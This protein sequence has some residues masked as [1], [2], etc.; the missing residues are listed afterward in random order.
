MILKGK[1]VDAC[2]VLRLWLTDDLIHDAYDNGADG[3]PIHPQYLRSRNAL[4]EN[5]DGFAGARAGGVD[6]K[7]G[8][9]ANVA[10][11]LNR[12]NHHKFSGLVGRMFQCGN[13]A[14]EHAG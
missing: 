1:V 11:W 9:S 3:R 14:A 13:N 8:V 10:I 7:Q 2:P 6:G 5:E 4:A 12:L